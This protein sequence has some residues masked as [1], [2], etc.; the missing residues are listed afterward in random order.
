MTTESAGVDWL[1]PLAHAVDWGTNQ[2]LQIDWTTVEEHLGSRLPSDYKQLMER[3]GKGTFDD[4]YIDLHLPEDLVV[5][6]GFH[7]ETGALPWASNEQELLLCWVTDGADPDAWP[8]CVIEAGEDVGD[9]FE[10][11][12]TEL[13]L[14]MLTYPQHPY[15]DPRR[16]HVALV[17]SRRQSIPTCP[18]RI[19]RGGTV[20]TRAK[21]AIRARPWSTAVRL[22][23]GAG[24]GSGPRGR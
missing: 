13:I 9:R 11:T 10:C 6:A 15:T 24:H 17:R 18:T 8:V 5:W 2:V 22:Q 23:R 12:A 1:Q 4:G 14:Q 20:R 21:A 16:L 7:E 3:F 19:L